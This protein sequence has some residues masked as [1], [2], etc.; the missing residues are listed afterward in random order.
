MYAVIFRAVINKLDKRY[1]ETANR[2]RELAKTQY[3]CLDFIAFTEGDREIA[4]S[5]WP[6]Q[7]HI[8]AWQDDPEHRQA[9]LLG[10]TVWYLSYKVEVVKIE[11]EYA[12][13]RS[14]QPE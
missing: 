5:Y 1:F 14:G 12:D 4:I 8:S 3:G 6:S 13:R 9:Q 11:R 10:R 2:L 7:S